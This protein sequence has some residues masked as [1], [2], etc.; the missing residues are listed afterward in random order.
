MALEDPDFEP[1]PL[2]LVEPELAVLEDVAVVWVEPVCDPVCED[3]PE[4]VS[5][6]AG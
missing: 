2:L 5:A 6:M 3:E 1:D 4:P